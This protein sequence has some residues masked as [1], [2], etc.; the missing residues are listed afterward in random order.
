MK[1]TSKCI[2]LALMGLFLFETPR[3]Q[4]RLEVSGSISISAEA[5]FYV[6]LASHG[7]WVEVDSYGRCWQPSGIAVEWRPYCY[8]EWVW[9]DHGWYWESDEP[10]AWAC[11]HYGR[12]VYHPRHHWVWVPGVEWAPAWVSW[13]VGGGYVGWAPLAPSHVSIRVGLPGPQFVFVQSGHFHERVRPSTVIVN[14]TTIINKT[15]VVSREPSRETRVVSGKKQETYVNSGPKPDQIEKGYASKMKPVPIQQAAAR[16]S[17]PDSIKSNRGNAA[18]PE[19]MKAPD[20]KDTPE[21]GPNRPKDPVTPEN[22]KHPPAPDHPKP[23]PQPDPPKPQPPTPE[24]P[25]KPVVPESPSDHQVTPG[26]DSPSPGKSPKPSSP[27]KS[28]GKPRKPGGGGGGH[29]KGPH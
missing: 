18:K 21:P 2:A 6:P 1:A 7:A 28:P 11:Y 9:T 27:K 22:P 12:W 19:P 24:N 25:K 4:A 29:G 16:T 3:A 26:K 14:N 10:W 15:K 8:G 17:V 5:D 13:R 23:A 20:K